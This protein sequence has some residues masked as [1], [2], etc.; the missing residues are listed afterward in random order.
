MAGPARLSAFWTGG[1][2]TI[3]NGNLTFAGGNT[4]LGDN[5]IAG[6]VYNNDPLDGH[7]ADRHHRQFRP[8]GNGRA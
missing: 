2:I 1:T 3:G 8:V 4:A 7:D 5:I 6:T